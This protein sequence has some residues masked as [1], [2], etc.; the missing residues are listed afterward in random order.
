MREHR[1]ASTTA[2]RA[3]RRVTALGVV[4]AAL[5]V[6]SL[7]VLGA[8]VLLRQCF[9]ATAW[10]APFVQLDVLA[11]S[12]WCP[13]GVGLGVVGKVAV[14]VVHAAVCLLAL[15][16][17]LWTGGTGLLLVAVGHVRDAA[18]LVGAL[19]WRVPR[20]RVVAGP[21]CTRAGPVDPRVPL[22]AGL[23]LGA[24]GLHRGP[25]AVV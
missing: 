1:A 9:P 10:A 13:G 11:T 8:D 20:R 4:L 23:R 6:V 3:V 24:W 19:L 16:S 5:P 2:A 25:P 14:L 21:R 22:L 18:A 15:H 17:L 12:A 7:A